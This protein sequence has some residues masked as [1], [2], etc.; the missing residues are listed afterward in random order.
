MSI[1]S[2][3][4]DKGWLYRSKK[5]KTKENLENVRS[6]LSE[7]TRGKCE[8]KPEEQ[9]NAINNLKIFYK[10]RQKAI[11]LFDEYTTIVSK[12]KCAAKHRNSIQNINK[13]IK[14]YQ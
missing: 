7:I 9:K 12:A 1:S 4:K 5:S 8:H 2:Y 11:T 14:N 10:A 3:K 6:N 13:C